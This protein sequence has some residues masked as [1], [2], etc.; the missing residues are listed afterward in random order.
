MTP[1][2]EIA[3]LRRSLAA[4]KRREAVAR[5]AWQ[6]DHSQWQAHV[7]GYTCRRAVENA[8][9]KHGAQLGPVFREML[10]ARLCVVDVAPDGSTPTIQTA[11]RLVARWSS[12]GARV[13]VSP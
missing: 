2:Q 4:A 9:R 5:D 11:V 13:E 10:A 3:I 7:D 12:E 8:A 1:A 6:R